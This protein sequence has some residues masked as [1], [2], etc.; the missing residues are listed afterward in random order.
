MS[1]D[2]AADSSGMGTLAE[3]DRPALKAA[4]GW[5]MSP[6][7]RLMAL[8]ARRTTRRVTQ[9]TARSANCERTGVSELWVVLQ[10]MSARTCSLM[11][12]RSPKTAHPPMRPAT[13]V[14]REPCVLF[15][16]PAPGTPFLCSSRT[17]L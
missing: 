8:V 2:L 15:A 12:F 17:V 3:S 13:N 14:S 10:M 6:L 1:A 16:V 5:T 7:M 4:A 11:A 9:R